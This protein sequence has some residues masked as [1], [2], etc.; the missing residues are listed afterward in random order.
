M[1]L[2]TASPGPRPCTFV[3]PAHSRDGGHAARDHDHEVERVDE[4]LLPAA[5]VTHLTNEQEDERH[6]EDVEQPALGHVPG[7]RAGGVGGGPGLEGGDERHGED[8]C[9]AAS[10]GARAW[11]RGRG[12]AHTHT[13]PPPPPNASPH[14]PPQVAAPICHLGLLARRLAG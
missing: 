9:R 3:L 1:Y 5:V 12:G 4:P 6:G 11:R 10:T 8:G 13:P 7:G 2:C 14:M